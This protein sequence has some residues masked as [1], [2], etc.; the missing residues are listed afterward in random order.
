MPGS[1]ESVRWNAYVH[2]QDFG[3]YS[4]PKEFGENG[5]QTHVN[6]K[7]KIP[8]TGSSEDRIRDTV[9]RWTGSPTHYQLSY[10]GPG[11]RHIVWVFSGMLRLTVVCSRT[12]ISLSQYDSVIKQRDGRG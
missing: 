10:S 3:L 11:W 4:Y 2:R 6:S 12:W 9:S 1:F 7:G 8:S 5:V